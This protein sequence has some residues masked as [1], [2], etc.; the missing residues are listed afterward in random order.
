MKFT[1]ENKDPGSNARTGTITTDHGTIQT[2]IFMPVGTAGTVKAVHQAE[3][4]KEIALEYL[5]CLVRQ[6]RTNF[7]ASL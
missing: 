2:P 6:I 3:L 1:L 4:K 7:V 5:A